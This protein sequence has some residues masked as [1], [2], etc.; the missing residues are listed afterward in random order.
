MNQTYVSIYLLKIHAYRAWLRVVRI[1]ISRVS[2]DRFQT[3][4]IYEYR[5]RDHFVLGRKEERK[6]KVS[7][8]ISR[9]ARLLVRRERE[10]KGQRKSDFWSGGRSQNSNDFTDSSHDPFLFCRS[11]F[12]ATRRPSRL[13]CRGSNGHKY[14][15]QLALPPPPPARFRGIK[16]VY[17]QCNPITK[18]L[19]LIFHVFHEI[20][21]KPRRLFISSKIWFEGERESSVCFNF[22]FIK[23]FKVIRFL[24]FSCQADFNTLK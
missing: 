7:V 18:F 20:E 19:I 1:G 11:L 13:I 23:I 3:V 4:S 15:Q 6:D 10:T 21:V 9:H 5:F 12:D 16:N 14:P 24:V 22:I 8:R 2:R 17:V